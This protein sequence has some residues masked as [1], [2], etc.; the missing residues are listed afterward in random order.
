MFPGFTDE[1]MVEEQRNQMH[2]YPMAQSKDLC[3]PEQ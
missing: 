3:V 1:E 2:P